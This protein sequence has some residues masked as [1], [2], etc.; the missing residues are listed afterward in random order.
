MQ[1]A[2][3]RAGGRAGD[4]ANS[5]D[6]NQP[7]STAVAAPF[8][9]VAWERCRAAMFRHDLEHSVGSWLERQ[10]IYGEWLALFLAGGGQAS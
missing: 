1:T 7:L 4:E 5:K 6:K 8:Q 3:P 10:R 2:P 9:A